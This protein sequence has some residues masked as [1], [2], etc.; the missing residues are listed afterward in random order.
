MSTASSAAD[1][2]SLDLSLATAARNP[3]GSL[4]NN[5]LFKLTAT[6]TLIDKGVNVSLPYLGS[7][8]DLGAF[9]KH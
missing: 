9:E 7:A 5:N 1:F 6:S 4:P 2:I 3:D 8:P